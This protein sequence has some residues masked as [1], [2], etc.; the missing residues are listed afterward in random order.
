[1]S[2]I[3]RKS[4]TVPD[5][6]KI[7]NKNGTLHVNGPKGEIK[8]KIPQGIEMNISDGSINITRNSEDKR[9]KAFH[10]LT[11]SLIENAIIGVSEGFTKILEIVGT[12]YK[13]ELNGK[14][15]LKMSLGYS[16]PIDFKL[17]SNVEAKVEDRGT[18][19]ILEGI[20]K[21]LVGETAARVRKL[22]KP[23]SYKGKGVRYRGETLRLK[24][25][26]AGGKTA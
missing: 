23:D 1:M 24:P 12:G 3:G 20:D 8:V 18:V 7:D 2:R 17:P 14:D 19:L 13:A 15:Q 6:V 10:G 21:Q 16:N 26:K 4:I 25:G 11:R 9:V 5:S 22:R